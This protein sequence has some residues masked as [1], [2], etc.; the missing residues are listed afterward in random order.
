MKKLSKLIKNLTFT[1]IIGNTNKE[2]KSIENDS[3]KCNK[4]SLFVAI[5]GTNSDGHNYIGIA[6]KQGTEVIVCEELDSSVEIKD[7]ITFI[8]VENSRLALA[9]LAH[10]LYDFPT[11]DMNVIGI[12]GTNGKTTITFLIKSILD[13]AG[14][15]SAIIGTTG[16]YIGDSK[17]PSTHTTP[18][19]LQLCNYLSQM[20]SEGVK[21]VIMEVS[22]HALSQNRVTGITFDIAAFTNLTHDHL[23]YHHTLEDY[24]SAKKLLFQ[25]LKPEGIAIVNGDDEHADFILKNISAKNLKI[26]RKEFND[27]IITGE[28]LNLDET[29]FKLKINSKKYLNIKTNLLG[30][31]NID[32]S[33]MAAVICHQIGIS[34]KTIVDSLQNV[35][36]APG[37]MQKII[38]K[39]GAIALVDYAHTPDALEKA[40]NSCRE[41]MNSAGLINNKLICVFGCGG[42]RDK[43]KRPIMGKLSS[44]IA[45]FSIITD[46]NPRT[47]DSAKIIRDIYYGIDNG[48]KKK[49]IQISNRA[50]AIK[51]AFSISKDNDIILVAGKG[52]E[53]YQIIGE[54]KHHFDDNEELMKFTD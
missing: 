40:L 19:P 26:G 30:R 31:F 6:I 50:E 5:R 29:V 52:H 11:R 28:N 44:R 12:T 9:E 46:D 41:A 38:L 33:A 35:S 51:Y 48:N 37:R 36:G 34:D 24:A 20:K 2:I 14:E 4:G 18:D 47:E 43:T 3:R 21:Y 25:M 54:V 49:V 7:N 42:D 22:S 45:D 53:T 1:Q 15:K 13:N 32:N 17:L 16:I 10:A 8:I 23:D 39:N 27:V